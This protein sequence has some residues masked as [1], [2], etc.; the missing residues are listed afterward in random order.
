MTTS[1]L[2]MKKKEELS[3]KLLDEPKIPQATA[4]VNP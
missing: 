1:V 3:M 2:K 4:R